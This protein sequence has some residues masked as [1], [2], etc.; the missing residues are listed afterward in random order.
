M[1]VYNDISRWVDEGFIVDVALC[2]LAKAFDVNHSLLLEKL[3]LIG[4]GDPLLGWVGDFL[5]CRMMRVVVSDCLS[6]DREELSGVPQGSVLG[7]LLF[8]IYVCQQSSFFGPV[9]VCVVR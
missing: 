1:L 7:P 4:I 8:I 3:R 2:D 5:S 6:S 9:L